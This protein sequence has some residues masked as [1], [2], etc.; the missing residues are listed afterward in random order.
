MCGIKHRVPIRVAKQ[1]FVKGGQQNGDQRGELRWRINR[2]L[3]IELGM[4]FSVHPNR[5]HQVLTRLMH[6]IAFLK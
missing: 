4:N 3:A 5:V 2:S 1:I 6:S